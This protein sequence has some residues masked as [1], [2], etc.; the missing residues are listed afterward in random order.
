MN[1]QNL[2]KIT[3]VI[4]IVTIT[5][6]ATII[7]TTITITKVQHIVKRVQTIK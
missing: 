3:I 5:I 7:I 1:S 4:E 6:T 2:K